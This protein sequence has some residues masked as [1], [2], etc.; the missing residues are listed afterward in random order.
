MVISEQD[1]GASKAGSAAKASSTD[2]MVV[3]ERGHCRFDLHEFLTTTP[4]WVAR[5]DSSVVWDGQCAFISADAATDKGDM[6]ESQDMDVDNRSP[7][8][9][10][11]RSVR[12]LRKKDL[13][14]AWNAMMKTPRF[15]RR[16]LRS[17]TSSLSDDAAADPV[18]AAAA[19]MGTV[20]GIIRR[21]SRL[22]T[23]NGS[24]CR[25]CLQG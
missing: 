5:N 15:M 17:K 19:T 24:T 23:S 6:N 21:N 22:E 8:M 1:Q 16:R 2:S 9:Q 20:R 3:D 10:R 4:W 25:Y 11:K 12:S 7:K 18:I 14:T 13:Y